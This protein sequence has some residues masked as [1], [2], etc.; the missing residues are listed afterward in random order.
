MFEMTNNQSCRYRAHRWGHMSRRK[1]KTGG[2]CISLMR[3]STLTTNTIRY[4]W[5]GH[6]VV[7]VVCSDIKGGLWWKLRAGE[8]YVLHF[9]YPATNWTWGKQI[10]GKHILERHMLTYRQTIEYRTASQ[11]WPRCVHTWTSSDTLL[12][13]QCIESRPV[14]WLNRSGNNPLTTCIPFEHDVGFQLSSFSSRPRGNH[15]SDCL[16]RAVL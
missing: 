14:W 12:C 11:C 8:K 4:G 2:K 13:Q 3:T 7:S 5:K 16:P 15:V 6:L 9:T 10:A 1:D